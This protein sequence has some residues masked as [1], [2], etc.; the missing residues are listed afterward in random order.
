MFKLPILIK[1]N[2]NNLKKKKSGSSW[3]MFVSGQIVYYSDNGIF[4]D[5]GG[6]T[7]FHVKFSRVNEGGDKFFI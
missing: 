6:S 7:T 2:N 5:R 3:M 1:N 4:S